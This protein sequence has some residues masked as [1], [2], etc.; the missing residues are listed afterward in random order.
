[1]TEDGEVLKAKAPVKENADVGEAYTTE[2]K[3]FD[4]YVFAKMADD[5]ADANGTVQKGYQTVTYV[6]K[7]T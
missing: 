4:D 7:K 2:L 1:M 3:S 5:S 6:Y